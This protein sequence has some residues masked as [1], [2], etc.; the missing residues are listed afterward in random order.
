MAVVQCQARFRTCTLEKSWVLAV[1][2]LLKQCSHDRL[3]TG[4]IELL[5]Q[6]LV[7]PQA[8]DNCF[9]KQS[10]SLSV[11]TVS[12]NGLLIMPEDLLEL[13]HSPAVESQNHGMVWVGSCSSS[14]STPCHGQGHPLSTL[15]SLALVGSECSALLQTENLSV[16]RD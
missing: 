12:L 3:L 14:R 6:H 2:S 7:H 16:F 8:P 9:A 10:Q 1:R 13:C 5:L 11:L 4:K 15:S